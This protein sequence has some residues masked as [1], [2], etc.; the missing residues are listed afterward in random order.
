MKILLH[1]CCG[2]CATEALRSFLVEGHTVK[3]F[4]YG[5]N[6]HPADEYERRLRAAEKVCEKM[7]VE[8]ITGAYDRQRWFELVKGKQNEPEGGA[9]CLVCFRMRLSQTFKR[10]VGENADRF[11]TT[12]TISP[13]K[14]AVAINS[15]GAELGGPRYIPTDFKKKGGYLNSVETAKKMGLYRQ[16]Y[17]GCVYSL[18]SALRS[19]RKESET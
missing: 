6:I 10:M 17:C 18:E 16:R 14:D 8:L 11:A 13:H 4:F 9:R 19:E 12:L 3:G 2:P 7:G 5:P 1:I 15:L